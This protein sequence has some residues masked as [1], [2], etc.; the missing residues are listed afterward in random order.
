MR[1][2]PLSKIILFKPWMSQHALEANMMK[3]ENPDSRWPAKKARVFY[4]IF[5]ADEVSRDKAVY[6]IRGDKYHFM[7]E[8]GVSING[9]SQDGVRPPYLVIAS[10]RRSSTG[11]VICSEA[12]AHAIY[13]RTCPVPV[14][15]NLERQTLDSLFEAA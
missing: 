2:R 11:E 6:E 4:Q 1:G 13:S 9:E 7:P 15:S 12:Y 8:K 5:V 14:D 3:L 10:Y